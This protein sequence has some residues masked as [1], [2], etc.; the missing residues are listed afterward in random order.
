[1]L[2]LG[3][4]T[5]GR[6]GGVALARGDERSFAVLEVAALDGGTY[7]AQLVP[8]IGELLRKH[9]ISKTEID[10][11][12]V[13][14]GPGSFTGLR[15]GLSTVKGLAEALRKP[16]ATVSVLE[17]IAAQ[18]NTDG[19]VIAALDAGRKDIFA[20]EYEV[21]GSQ[22]NVLCESLLT[23]AQFAALLEANAGAEL[24]TPHA[25]ISDLAS[26]HLHLK[27]VEWPD[28]GEVARLGYN[29]IRAGRVVTPEA[30]DANYIRRSD[31][32]IFSK[33]RG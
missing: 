7:S 9:G 12:A 20:G 24:V 3:V 17:L 21:R 26:M 8:R 29:R 1:M 19:R 30:L 15:V 14:S 6:H 27:Q 18:T 31:A 32:E 28:A 11:F 13:A 4:D 25:T 2:L 22:P 10:A 23:Q 5:S 16:I 33:N